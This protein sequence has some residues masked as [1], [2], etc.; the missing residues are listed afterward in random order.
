MTTRE[1]TG[2]HMYR[3]E[4]IWP[5]L[6]VGALILLITPWVGGTLA[7]VVVLIL[8]V[9]ILV[10]LV[11]AIAATPFLLARAVLRR[12][13]SDRGLPAYTAQAKVRR[14]PLPT[15]AGEQPAV[16][17]TRAAPVRRPPLKP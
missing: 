16:L 11:G 7:V 2:D 9:A 6:P 17:G 1:R 8:A 4:W 13:R 12:R 5:L 14:A 15:A 3:I 10:A